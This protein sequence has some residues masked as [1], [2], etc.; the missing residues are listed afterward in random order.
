[1]STGTVTE[2]GRRGF[3]KAGITGAAGFGHRLLF[4]RKSGGF[5][6]TSAWQCRRR[7]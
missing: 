6:G 1:M 3:L 2:I 7:L 5:R 4:A